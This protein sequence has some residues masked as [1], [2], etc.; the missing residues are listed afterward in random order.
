MIGCVRRM[1][2]ALYSRTHTWI[3]TPLNLLAYSH[4]DVNY[5]KS[6]RG[7]GLAGEEVLLNAICGRDW[8][9]DQSISLLSGRHAEVLDMRLLGHR[10]V[11]AGC[12]SRMFSGKC[13]HQQHQHQKKFW[14]WAEVRAHAQVQQQG[15]FRA[16]S[17]GMWL[18]FCCTESNL[19]Q[20]AGCVYYLRR[21]YIL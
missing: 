19:P 1:Y 15:R 8:G 17:E 10:V 9:Y 11:S 16:G 13:T 7:K 12:I 20:P 21:C 18:C 2:S 4:A 5:G 14:V 3:S 6:K